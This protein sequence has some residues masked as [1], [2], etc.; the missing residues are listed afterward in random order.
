MSFSPLMAVAINDETYSLQ[1]EMVHWRWIESF[2]Y[3]VKEVK[4]CQ[5]LTISHF[6]APERFL[7]FLIWLEN[8]GLL[9]NVEL[10]SSVVL[11]LI[12]LTWQTSHWFQWSKEPQD[13]TAAMSLI[14]KHL[15]TIFIISNSVLYTHK[16]S[17]KYFIC[18]YLQP[19]CK[20]VF[21]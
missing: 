1:N 10:S 7:L 3:F 5:S 2:S 11:L 16:C 21:Q 12:G 6:S 8:D 19:K 15:N 20:V 13:T 4:V 14:E 17:F 9:N 18:R